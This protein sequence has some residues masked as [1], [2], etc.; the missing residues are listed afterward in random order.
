MYLLFK[1]KNGDS[2]MRIDNREAY[3]F[4]DVIDRGISKGDENFD[5]KV[6]KMQGGG[7]RTKYTYQGGDNATM[8]IVNGLTIYLDNGV[9]FYVV[10]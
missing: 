3:H 9:C 5:C 7:K 6:V 1:T 2:F 10:Y 4:K 8:E